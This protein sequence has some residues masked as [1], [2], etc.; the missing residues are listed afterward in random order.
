VFWIQTEGV[1]DLRGLVFFFDDLVPVHHELFSSFATAMG[2][3]LG[4]VADGPPLPLSAAGLP[5]AGFAGAGFA[6][7]VPFF[8]F[9]NF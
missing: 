3:Y 4:S 8:I 5:P 9:V 2:V 6:G 1:I 7:A